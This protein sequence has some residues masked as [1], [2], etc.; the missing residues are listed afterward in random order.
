MPKVLFYR[1]SKCK[2]DYLEKNIEQVIV[3]KISLK[4]LVDGS[5]VFNEREKTIKS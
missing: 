4:S 5:A 1:L 2:A 3:K